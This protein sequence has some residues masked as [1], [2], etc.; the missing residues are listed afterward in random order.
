M[1]TTSATV[2]HE[3]FHALGFGH[4]HSRPDRDNFITVHEDRTD[5]MSQFS[6]I[7]NWMDT[8]EDH[9][10]E[11]DSVMTYCSHC[12]SNGDLPVM[13]TKVIF[14]L[15]KNSHLTFLLFSFIRFGIKPFFT[16]QVLKL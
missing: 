4:E 8:G 9:P 15:S 2:E 7:E 16:S 12:G 5:S 14:R 3:V 10:F 6:L 11:L 13:T 1:G